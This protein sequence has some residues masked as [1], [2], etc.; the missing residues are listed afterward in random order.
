MTVFLGFFEKAKSQKTRVL[1]YVEVG[2]VRM[3]LLVLDGQ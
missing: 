1:G 2:V 3:K